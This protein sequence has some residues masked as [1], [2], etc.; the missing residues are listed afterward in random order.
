[1]TCNIQGTINLNTLNLN[2]TNAL[3][4]LN[5]SNINLGNG[6]GAIVNISS[7]KYTKR[8][9]PVLQY[10]VSAK[11]DYAVSK[12]LYHYPDKVLCTKCNTETNISQL[13]TGETLL[14]NDDVKN[15][16]PTAKCNKCHLSSFDIILQSYLYPYANQ[17]DP[18]LYLHCSNS[19]CNHT[20]EWI[21]TSKK[22]ETEI[23]VY[24]NNWQKPFQYY[25]GHTCDDGK[26]N[27]DTLLFDREYVIDQFW[28]ST[29][30]VN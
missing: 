20:I 18:V 28:K 19:F 8:A 30:C 27:I 11:Y 22:S 29:D 24:D 12:C 7:E 3:K 17:E 5:Y 9:K 26:L 13:K 23:N 21:T 6:S 1:M 14:S 2:N 25:D 4:L 16:L 15:K 10:I